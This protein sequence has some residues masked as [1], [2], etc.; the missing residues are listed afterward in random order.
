M[1]LHV[2]IYKISFSNSYDEFL[3]LLD[4]DVNITIGEDIPDPAVYEMLVYPT[5]TQQWLE[6]SPNLRAIVIPW[7]GVPEKTRKL[8]AAYPQ[9][10]VHNLHHNRYNTAELG[11]GLLLAAAKRIIPMDQALRQNDWSPHY[12]KSKAIL[13]RN[14][15]ALILGYGEIGQALGEYCQGLGMRVVGIKNHPDQLEANQGIEIV[16]TDKLHER[17]PEADVLLI[18]L[19]LTDKTEDLIGAKEIALLPEGSILVNVGRGPVVNQY[20]LYDALKSGHLRAAG[21][22]VWYNYPESKEARTNTPPADVPFGELDNFVLSPHRGGMVED[23]EEQSMHALAAL[24][25]TASR[26]MPIPN[27]VD[28]EKGY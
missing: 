14:R 7:A 13:L 19:P 24:I 12:E 5:P 1:P 11:F 10:S 17:L 20:A 27:Q 23:G 2:H 8:M 4:E 3:S 9:I 6:A 28:L 18:A 25:N 16:G 21:N 15:T 26:G 22:D